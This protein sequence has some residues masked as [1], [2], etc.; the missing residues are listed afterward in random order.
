MNFHNQYIQVFAELGIVGFLLLL[1]MLVLSISNAIASKNYFHIAFSVL[2]LSLFITE[3]FLWR[4]RGVTFFI[5]M[6]CVLNIKV[7]SEK[8]ITI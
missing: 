6:Y 4:Q 5:V 7:K 3:S 8:T 2:M 1:L